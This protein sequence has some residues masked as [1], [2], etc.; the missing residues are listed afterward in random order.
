MLVSSG[1][2]S[3]SIRAWPAGLRSRLRAH[4]L[5]SSSIWALKS[6]RAGS[7]AERARAPCHGRNKWLDGVL[8]TACRGWSVRGETLSMCAISSL[9]ARISPMAAQHDE[10]DS[11]AENWSLQGRSPPESRCKDLTCTTGIWIHQFQVLH[12]S[13]FVLDIKTMESKNYVTSSSIHLVSIE[14][15]E[16]IDFKF[17][18]RAL[19]CFK[20][21]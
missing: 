13:H 21:I 3:G 18:Q 20:D 1:W 6:C 11:D 9:L 17:V 2:S 5:L 19:K 4:V 7:R 10:R 8:P 16:I 12:Q 14:F 15:S